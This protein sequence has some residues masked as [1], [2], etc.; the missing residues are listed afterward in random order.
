MAAVHSV[1]ALRTATAVAI[2]KDPGS[3]LP[4]HHLWS[5][6]HGSI[7]LLM[8]LMCLSLS[9]F[10]Q[11]M[12]CVHSRLVAVARHKQAQQRVRVRHHIRS[13][14]QHFRLSASECS[15]CR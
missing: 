8:Q 6:Q 11:Y 13:G 15:L 1:S 7:I 14:L 4:L 10:L 5:R 9:F 2:C 3:R 12:Q